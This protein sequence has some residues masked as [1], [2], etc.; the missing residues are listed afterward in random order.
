LARQVRAITGRHGAAAAA[1]AAA[2]GAATAIR[3]VADGGRLATITSDPPSQ[4][5]GITVS[6][7]YV[8]ADGNQLEEL[9]QQFEDGQLEI[10]VAASYHLTEAA[11]APA[12]AT[13][14]HPAGVITLT[15]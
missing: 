1:N 2:D 6:S 5:R 9:A 13:G 4:Q 12:Q 8:R 7:I 3:A 15:P 10:P 11:Q 14:G